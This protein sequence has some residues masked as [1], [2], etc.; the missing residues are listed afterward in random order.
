MLKITGLTYRYEKY[1]KLK[2]PDF[3]LERGDQAL[4]LGQSGCGKTTLLHL[5]AG[6]LKPLSGDVVLGGEV[7]SKMSGAALD[8]FRGKNIGVVFQ[9]PHF[10]EALTVKENILLAQKLSGNKKD[11]NAV[12][13]ILQDLGIEHKVDSK[14]KQLSQGEKQRVTIARA[15]ITNPRLILADEP[16][17]ALD[18]DNCTSVVNLLKEQAKKHNATLLIVTH[19]TRL[20]KKFEKSIL[21]NS[22][23]VKSKGSES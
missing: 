7:T 14:V 15:L 4:I 22:S 21:L 11:V 1:V 5:L 2:F 9:V 23:D 8:N 20:K 6:L 10:I 16:T 17:S 12:V 3:E 18:D 13:S 19:D